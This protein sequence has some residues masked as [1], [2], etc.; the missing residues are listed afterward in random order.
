VCRFYTAYVVGRKEV[1]KPENRHT[2]TGA[3]LASKAF[4][5]YPAS[6]VSMVMSTSSW[7]PNTSGKQPA[8]WRIPD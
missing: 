5:A 8:K 4:P 3:T 6:N 7:Q 1:R 2:G